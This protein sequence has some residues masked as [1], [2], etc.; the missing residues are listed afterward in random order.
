LESD[1]ISFS[2]GRLNVPDM[3][4]IPFVEGDGT[5][6]DIWKAASRVI[7]RAVEICWQGK[8]KIA[9][10]EVLAGGKGI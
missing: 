8:R 2:D 5:G 7:D 6:P 1:R 3:P 4:V 10:K 9:W